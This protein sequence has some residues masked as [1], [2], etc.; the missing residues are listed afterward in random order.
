MIFEKMKKRIVTSLILLSLIFLIFKYDFILV[1][2]L[3][4]LGVISL[5]EFFNI[6]KKM[7]K[8]KMYLVFSNLIFSTYVFIFCF[9]FIFFSNFIQL[10][11]ILYIILLGCVS[12]DIGGF[13]FGKIFKGPK[14]SKISPNKTIAGAFGS[15]I[16]TSFVM[17]GLF[18]YLMQSFNFFILIVCIFT[19][20]GCQL[21]DLFFS[22]LKR[23]VSLK[24]TG[25]IFPGHGGALD[26]V[27]GILIGLPIGFIV[28]ITIF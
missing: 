28:L 18:Y 1:Y 12:S 23:K 6:S 9:L 10:K 17:S 13:I 26:R 7:F 11:I 20:I 25:N 14:L 2:S 3:L 22:L 19:S 8:N 4:I 21:G 5:L 15:L 24:D 27:D 16:L